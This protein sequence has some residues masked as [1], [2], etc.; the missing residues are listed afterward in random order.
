MGCDIHCHVE[1]QG[2]DGKWKKIGGFVSDYYDP[3]NQFFSTDEYKN[4][5]SP[6]DAR[7]YFLFS[8]LAGVRSDGKGIKPIS[9]PKGLPDDVTDEVKADSDE[10]G[11]DGHSH[12]WLTVQ[13]IT[14]GITGGFECEGVVG[15][16]EYRRFKEH[17][18]PSSWC[19]S[20]GG[21]SI[22]CATNS[23]MDSIVEQG[24]D[25]NPAMKHLVEGYRT[26][27]HWTLKAEDAL[28]CFME[29][30]LPQLVQRCEREDQSDV[31]IVFW[32]DN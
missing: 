21:P 5:D 20:V 31:R 17:G 23:E 13:E 29:K 27:V 18:A 15:L 2:G 30:T 9:E 11:I 14:E 22:T 19:G 8:I 12:S 7:S 10:W 3:N 16:D 26:V 6:I 24:W 32:F 28:K 25:A 4:A 1:K